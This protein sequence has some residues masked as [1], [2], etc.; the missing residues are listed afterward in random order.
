MRKGFLGSIMIM[1]VST[2][3]AW[4]QNSRPSEP[5]T[6]SVSSLEGEQ[7]IDTRFQQTGFGEPNPI[8]LPNVPVPA[9]P[10]MAG[11]SSGPVYP[12]P[13]IY[14]EVNPDTLP[15]PEENAD[16]H[17][18]ERFWG[19]ADYL[20]FF[21]KSQPSPYPM[22]TT[23]IPSSG[24][25]LNQPTTLPL[26]GQHDIQYN[27]MSG[28]R[29]DAGMYIDD[30]N[31]LGVDVGGFWLQK[32]DQ[33][34]TF[35]S[36]AA[37]NPLLAIPFI[38]AVTGAQDAVT[39]NSQGNFGGSSLIDTTT[40]VYS[41]DGNMIWNMYRGCATACKSLSLD[42]LVGVRFAQL[43]ESLTQ[44]ST[45]TFLGQSGV[46]LPPSF[47]PFPASLGVDNGNGATLNILDKFH[48]LNQFYGG[49]IGLRS[50][51]RWN[52]WLFNGTYKLGFGDMHSTVDVFGNTTLTRGD[53]V[54]LTGSQLGGVYANA[55]N[56]SRLHRDTFSL[57]PEV[58]LKIGY[59]ITEHV[60]IF[61]GYTFFYMNNVVRPGLVRP[62]TLQ[63]GLI[64]ISPSYGQ[65][66]GV[67]PAI[68]NF[69]TTDFYAQGVS[70]GFQ[71][72]Y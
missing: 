41:V 60:Q 8:T 45:S 64:P 3:W 27:W 66:V 46:P 6:S 4:G 12:A 31:R 53:S 47:G 36:D 13:A 33:K 49:Q 72:K 30:W 55:Q 16:R 26:F 68:N 15:R 25:V 34:S 18:V 20:Y 67:L 1:I 29:V 39:L 51:F 17:E 40:Q 52:R 70:F 28:F 38:N 19:S 71:F 56:I 23:S 5:G 14:Q 62:I 35:Q 24:G 11:P 32:T 57:L 61:V 63:P 59:Q 21:V 58:N 54:P 22:L 50:N 44:I 7:P 43:E 69:Q 10:T 42:A 37:G 48:V 2:G 9:P 65:V